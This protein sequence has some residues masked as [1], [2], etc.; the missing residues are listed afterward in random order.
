MT[1]LKEAVSKEAM[2][3]LLEARLLT[4]NALKH[5]PSFTSSSWL[6]AGSGKVRP[7]RRFLVGKEASL[8][9]LLV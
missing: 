7:V 4:W 5:L 1:Q 3:F 6:R 8:V 2:M 9:D